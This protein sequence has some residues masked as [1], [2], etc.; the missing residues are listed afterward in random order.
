MTNLE[1]L[2]KEERELALSIL[3]EYSD[4]GVS[5]KLNELLLEDWREIP[6]DISTFIKDPQYLGRGLT[7]AEGRFTVFPYWQDLLKRIYPDP[8]KPAICNT[9][10]LTGAIG[11]GKT[12]IA[13]IIG[14][15]E[16][17]VMMCL[18]DPYVYYGLQ[19]IDKITFA[20]INITLDDARGVAWSKLQGL[21]QSSPW[22]MAHGKLSKSINPEWAPDINTN[23]ELIYGS[24]PRH[25]IGRALKF[26]FM[27]EIS[28]QNNMDVEK[29]KEKAYALVSEASSRMKSR[30]MRGEH[31]PTILVLASSK[32]TEQSFME[33]FIEQKKQ[34]ES[35]TTIVIDEPQWVIRTEKQSTRQFKVAIGNKF[36]PS[37]ILPFGTTEEEEN[38]YRD[39]GFK[40]IEV[41]IG[42]YEEFLDNIENAL[43]TVAGI[44]TTS[45]SSYI[46]GVKLSQCKLEEIKNP[47]TKDIITVGDGQ[48]DLAQYK[49]FF[50]LD[51]VDKSLMSRPLYI[52]LDLSLTGDKTGIAGVW[53][54]G[55][56]IPKA[57]EQQTSELTYQLA[58]VVSVKAPRGHQVS[59]EKTRNFIYWL[60]EQG[61]NIKGITSDT[62]AR[63]GIEQDF[64]RKGFKYEI[65][66]V[67]RTNSDHICEPY[68]YFKNTIYEKRILLPK[69]GINL[70]TEEI[71]GLKR[72]NNSGKVD[73]DPS[74]INSKDSSDAVCGALFNASKHAEEFGYE[75]GE[76]LD[77]LTEFN[78][79]ELDPTQS[80][81][82]GL[83]EY[84]KPN[85]E[86]FVDFGFGAA[87]EYFGPADG[88]ILW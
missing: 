33:T 67:D 60:K 84:G 6:V 22:F 62:Y 70:L 54:K 68:A 76:S 11:L 8:M 51:Y 69:L 61:F 87:Q 53:I 35:K 41:P 85:S 65:L 34:N 63:A 75:Y 88:V 2:S 83:L 37:E 56:K 14:L 81:E 49:D 57:D 73:H 47:F 31:N 43:M 40:I 25:F 42:Y 52:H 64:I 36:L 59:F 18:K 32:R 86:G 20:F 30:F 78:K 79:Q 3:K 74:G 82:S 26:A 29:Q 4:K 44:S 66:S 1:N 23:I 19:P 58:F 71:I 46:S 38:Y 55:K 50:N 45:I 10:A 77:I 9:L 48:D 28:F 17:Y 13:C 16:L 24:L 39:R 15:Y 12:L 5:S 21:L 27:D 7:D 80:F 72:D